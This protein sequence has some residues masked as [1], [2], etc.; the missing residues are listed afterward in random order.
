MLNVSPHIRDG[1]RRT[2]LMYAAFHGHSD[3]V[4]LLLDLGVG[5]NIYDRNGWSA[6]MLPAW[7][8]HAQS[9][10]LLLDCG[11]RVV[12]P[13]PSG[14]TALM[15]TATRGHTALVGL[16]FGYGAEVEVVNQSGSYLLLRAAGQATDIVQLLLTHGA[17][18][19]ARDAWLDGTRGSAVEQSARYR[20]ALAHCLRCHAR[21]IREEYACRL[22]QAGSEK[23]HHRAPASQR[24]TLRCRGDRSVAQ[25]RAR[26]GMPYA[27]Q[28][29]FGSTKELH[30]K[31]TS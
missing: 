12:V 23:S 31:A 14:I 19:T 21:D 8:G 1:E 16:F 27:S 3:M 11:A 30:L 6:L 10:Q 2:A 18:T 28:E 29:P 22:S 25:N 5:I 9:A 26:R 24:N 7:N 17:R 15:A 13:S 4:Q 20:D